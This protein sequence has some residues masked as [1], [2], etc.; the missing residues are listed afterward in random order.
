MEVKMK[1]IFGAII[2]VLIFNSTILSD[3][4]YQ[5]C[6]VA[7]GKNGPKKEGQA[8]SKHT[9]CDFGL[10]CENGACRKCICDFVH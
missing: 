8:C 4:G 10:L 5:D 6:W 9:E 3:C 1:N 7:G 2:M